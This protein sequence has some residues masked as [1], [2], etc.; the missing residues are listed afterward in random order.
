MRFASALGRASVALLVT[1]AVACGV[2]GSG[3]DPDPGSDIPPPNPSS[4][5]GILPPDASAP[6]RVNVRFAHAAPALGAVDV[7]YRVRGSDAF[8]GPLFSGN[9]VGDAGA[10]DAGALDDDSVDAGD[11][12]FT[13]DA[14]PAEGGLADAGD[15]D[16]AS[17]GGETF[18]LAPWTMTSYL[19]FRGAGTFDIALVPASSRTC[20]GARVV[21]AITVETGR[22]TTVVLSGV[23]E[24]ATNA[25]TNDAGPSLPVRVLGLVDDATAAPGVSRIRFV[26]AAPHTNEVLTVSG[27]PSGLAQ[28]VLAPRVEPR[29]V[30]TT[31]N[32][33][34][35]VDPLGYVDVAPLADPIAIRVRSLKDGGAI[36]FESEAAPL[37]LVPTSVHTGIVA[38]EGSELRVLFCSD[39]RTAEVRSSC[40]LL[41]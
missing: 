10:G 40:H 1:A 27:G 11:A 41:R 14:A 5:S 17:D 9:T 37:G 26:H 18:G 12:A 22:L 30:T 31:G 33:D 19:A 13:T 7:C 16:A 6:P 21:G 3:V 28:V 35:A 32:D 2:D 8:E 20:S 23:D 25:P 4:D 29:R 38:E 24:G 36:A 15:A 39:A 34:T